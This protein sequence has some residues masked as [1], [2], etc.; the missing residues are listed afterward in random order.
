[1]ACSAHGVNEKCLQSLVE[2]VG[3]NRLLGK[4]KN[5]REYNIKM[6]FTYV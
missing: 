5:R 2:N 3:G 1:V 4:I 6:D